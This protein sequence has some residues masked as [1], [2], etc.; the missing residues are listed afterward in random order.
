MNKQ[1]T[2]V[3][4]CKNE[5][6]GIIHVLRLLKKQKL[7]C[8]IIIA[9]SSDDNNTFNLL[10][11]YKI[12][13]PQIIQI[14]RGGLPAVARNRGA[15]LVKTP[16]VLFLDADIHIRDY[17]VIDTCLIKM[18]EGDYDLVTCRYKTIENKYNWVYRIFDIIQWVS[19]KTKPFA[20]GGFMLFKTETFNKLGGFNE[21]DKI[22]EDYHL[23]SKIK[24]NKFKIVNVYVH[25][26]DRRFKKKG[27]WYM[28]KLALNSWLNRNN[29][30]WFKQDYNYWK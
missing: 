8:N 21:E 22:A 5:G 28:T 30:E 6:I 12:H 20:I 2:I 13:S 19:S 25:T 7:D 14:I 18:I 29:D 4:P 17:D 16:Y 9:D 26:P 15:K 23:S 1:L 27:V 11:N 3:I 10:Y 24:P